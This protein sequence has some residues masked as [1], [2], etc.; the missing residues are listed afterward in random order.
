MHL[1]VAT[2]LTAERI[3]GSD[4]LLRL[5]ADLGTE[6]RQIVAGIGKAYSP[7]E[8][9][10]KQ[11]AVVTNLKPRKIMGLES[12]AMIIAAGDGSTLAVF[13]PEKP[14]KAGSIIG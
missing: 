3:K 14:V 13:N 9:I 8:L 4:K 6:K 10:G 12:E 5:E 7:E 2:I 1:K 11:V